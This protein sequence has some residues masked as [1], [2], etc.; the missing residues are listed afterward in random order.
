MQL[1]WQQYLFIELRTNEIFCNK[2][3]IVRRVQ[4]LT[5][6]RP[7]RSFSPGAVATTALCKSA[8]MPDINTAQRPT[9]ARP[10]APLAACV[11]R[12]SSV[13]NTKMD[14]HGDVLIRIEKLISNG[15]FYQRCK[16][17]DD[18]YGRL[19]DNWSEGIVENKK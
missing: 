2:L 4:F 5:E 8:P 14:W 3:D 6:R 7:M 15:Q 12:I 10:A 1:R 18:R 19:R 9:L 17:C 13:D 16:F 11:Q